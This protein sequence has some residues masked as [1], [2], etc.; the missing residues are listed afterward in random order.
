MDKKQNTDERSELDLFRDTM[1]DTCFRTIRR[2]FGMIDTMKS[3]ASGVQ[4]H[5]SVIGHECDTPR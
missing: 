3:Q 1:N 4:Y 5:Q 2:Q